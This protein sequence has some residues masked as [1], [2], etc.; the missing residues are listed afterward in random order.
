MVKVTNEKTENRQAY[1]TIEMEPAEVEESLEQAYHRLVQRAKI[2]G[3]RKGRTPRVIF[4]RYIGRESLLED[5]INNL[6]PQAYEKAIKEQAIEAIAQPQIEVTQTEPVVFKAIV[7][8]KPKIKLG[9]YRQVKVTQE[10]VSLTEDD[11][12][13]VIEALRHR[14]AN[15]NPVERPV[16]FGDL[17]AMDIWSDI[18][19]KPFLNQKG[20]QQQVLRDAQFP[21]PGFGEQ[22]VGLKRNEEKE[23]KLKFPEDF[24]RSEVAGKEV[25]FKVMLNE[26]KQEILPDL[27][28][29]F[30]KQVD[31]ALTTVEALKERATSDLK[32][33][34]EENSRI[35]FENR[36]IDVL[37]DLSEAEFPPVLVEA[38]IHQLIDQR[39]QRGQQELEEYL[40]NF[41]KTEEQLHE[42][43]RPVAIKRVTR[44]L[45]LGQFSQEQK[46][47]VAP[48][49]IDNEI[50][51]I[52]KSATENKEE[53]QRIFNTP[54]ARES[55]EQRLLSRKTVQRLMDLVKGEGQSKTTEKEG[56][57]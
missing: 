18:E 46:I 27:N 39:F 5:A 15:W 9:D 26:I 34:A 37:V 32:A 56:E 38:E 33:R 54:Q 36:A 23:F 31:S 35:D 13:R 10:P 44:S 41:N 16:E 52:L 30:A 6:V 14:H 42:E 4:E 43:L 47:E 51:T 21:A 45:V 1:L 40:K 29:D 8:L 48:S 50:E 25:Q 3:F 2:P 49:E 24:A 11:T 7:P 53:L 55:V 22:I 57:K 28:D 20:V 17:L 12:N 19:D